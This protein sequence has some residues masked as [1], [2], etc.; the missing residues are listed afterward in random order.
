[1][2]CLVAAIAL[3]VLPGGPGSAWFLTPEERQFATE[4]MQRD[5]ANFIQHEYGEDGLEK[6]RLSRRD[7]IETGK[8]WKL[9]YALVF[10]ICGSVPTQAFSVFLPLVLKGLGYS[11][12][13]ANLVRQ[14]R[15]CSL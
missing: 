4:R 9:W 15:H 3:F 14:R 13:E 5:T 7:V 2:T 8:D 6:D 12:I 1:L 11:S 10:N